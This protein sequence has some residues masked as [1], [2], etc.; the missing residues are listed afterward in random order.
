MKVLR[1]VASLVLK[2]LFQPQKRLI[3]AKEGKALCPL[4]LLSYF[5]FKRIAMINVFIK[6]TKQNETVFLYAPSL[7]ERINI[8]YALRIY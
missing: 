4:Y 6:K 3:R 1:A 5:R 7:K 8:Y 2:S